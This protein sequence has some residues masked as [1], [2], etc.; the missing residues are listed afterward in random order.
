MK[1]I[2]C[3]I[4]WSLASG[5]GLPS[6][7]EAEPE[8]PAQPEQDAGTPVQY[9]RDIQ[10]IWD[11]ACNGCHGLFD[12]RLTTSGSMANLRGTSFRCLSD[13]ASAPYLVPGH[14]EL[15][16]LFFKISGSTTLPLAAR[17][18]A[19]RDCEQL[20][21][22]NHLNPD[23]GA[24]LPLVATDPAAVELIRQWILSGAPDN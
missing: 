18:P 1:A 3:L 6:A 21:P 4:A 24:P 11:R 8:A 12:P 17:D 2:T 16:Y 9:R 14:P 23:G 10:P 22:P 15:S 19:R 20:M 13:G 7:P 5:C